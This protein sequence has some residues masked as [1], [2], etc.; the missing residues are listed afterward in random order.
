M[1]NIQSKINSLEEQNSKL[2]VEITELKKKYAGVAAENIEVKAE[3]AKLKRFIKENTELK[4]RIEELEKNRIETTTENAELKARVAKLEQNFEHRLDDSDNSSE[5]IVN[6]PNPVIDQCVDTNSKLLED[7]NQ[8]QDLSP[9]NHSILSDILCNTEIINDQDSRKQKKG[10]ALIQEI[11]LEKNHI[12]ENLSSDQKS[13]CITNAEASSLRETLDNCESRPYRA[14][15]IINLYQNACNAEESAMK[16]NQEEILCWCLY[17]KEF[18]DLVGDF[19]TKYNVSE[20]KA[21]GLV[22]G[23]IIEQLPN[24]KRENLCKQTQ[25]AIKIFN[26]FEKIGTDKVQ[27][28]KTYSANSISK[29]TNEELQKVIDYFTSNHDNSSTEISTTS[30]LSN[31]VTEITESSSENIPTESQEND[32]DESKTRSS[33]SSEL[34]EAEVNASTEETKSQVSDSSISANSETEISMPPISQVNIS[35]KSLSVL[36]DDPEKKRTHVIKMV[37]ERFSCLTLKYSNK[38]GDYFDC[39]KACLVCNKEH[40]RDNVK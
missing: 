18:K 4:T 15:N 38:Y 19:M 12:N 24:T 13:T 10:E 11:L 27:Y 16:A 29:F 33:A 34:P 20:K 6:V 36:P 25:R 28:I 35:N 32:Q 14:K 39:P 2:I 22:Y 3:N 1:A 17:A 7:K 37:L 23:F 5:N 30:G 21:K 31:H 9:V 26:L 40:K 8:S